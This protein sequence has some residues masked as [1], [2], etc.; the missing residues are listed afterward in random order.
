MEGLA[1]QVAEVREA[2]ADIVVAVD[3]C[4]PV[5]WAEILIQALRLWKEVPSLKSPT[6]NQQ[7]DF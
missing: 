1:F 5:D 7:L 3:V 4:S 6:A 2:G